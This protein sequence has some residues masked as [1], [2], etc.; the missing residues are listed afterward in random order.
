M[1][2]EDRSQRQH[3]Q[4]DERNQPYLYLPAIDVNRTRAD[5]KPGQDCQNSVKSHRNPE[6]LLRR[7]SGTL[8]ILGHALLAGTLSI[9]PADPPRFKLVTRGRCRTSILWCTGEDSNLRSSKERQIYSLLPLT[10]RPPVPFCPAE[11]NPSTTAAPAM[12]CRGWLKPKSPTVLPKVLPELPFIRYTTPASRSEPG[13]GI[14]VYWSH[15]VC[16]GR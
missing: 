16:C 5:G 12:P 15:G 13:S 6:L 7:V 9:Q 2:P 8:K 3:A 11:R 14:T 4:N 10:T 1:P